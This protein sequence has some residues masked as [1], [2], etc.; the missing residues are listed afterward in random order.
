[1]SIA[2]ALAAATGRAATRRVY[3]RAVAGIE[4]KPQRAP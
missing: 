1:V 3:P 2:T 4:K